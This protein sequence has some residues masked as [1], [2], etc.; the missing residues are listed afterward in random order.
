MP[1]DLEGEL[2]QQVLDSRVGRVSLLL[3]LA[4][5]N[6]LHLHSGHVDKS[7]H[8]ALTTGQP[9]SKERTKSVVHE[10]YS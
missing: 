7:T 10:L 6:A 1:A 5:Y 8:S 3:E 2:H 4:H 9:W